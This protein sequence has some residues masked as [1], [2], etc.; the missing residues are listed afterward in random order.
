TLLEDS[1]LRASQAVDACLA[2]FEKELQ[3]RVTN[4]MATMLQSFDLEAAARLAARLDQALATAKQRKHSIEQDLAGA[5]A[6]NRKR[7]DQISR[8]ATDGLQRRHQSLL[9]DLQ[10]EAERLLGELT[11]NANRIWDQL[12]QSGDNLS[13]ELKQHTE[14]AV[15]VFQLRI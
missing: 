6:E 4:E 5:V 11:K 2:G 8:G 12:Q 15:Q 9:E 10:K 1:Q 13:S 7:L 3:D 14:E